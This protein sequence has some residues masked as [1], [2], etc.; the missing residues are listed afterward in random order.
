MGLS[1]VN[2]PCLGISIY[3]IPEKYDLFPGN[4]GYCSFSDPPWTIEFT[5]VNHNNTVDGRNPNHQLQTVVYFS[6][7][8]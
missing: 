7:Y 6:H 1:I 5:N 4:V 3:E 8:L 2:H